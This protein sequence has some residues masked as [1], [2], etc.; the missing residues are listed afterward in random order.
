MKKKQSKPSRKNPFSQD[1]NEYPDKDKVRQA[2]TDLSNALLEKADGDPDLAIKLL[3]NSIS[4]NAP[5][6]TAG[7]WQ[8]THPNSIKCGSDSFYAKIASE[9][10]ADFNMIQT[11]GNIPDGTYFAAAQSIAAYLEDIVSGTQVWQAVR[12]IY[13]RTYGAQ[14]PFYEVDPEDYFDDDINIQDLKLL[15]WQALSRCGNEEERA[16]SPISQ[17]VSKMSEIAFDILVEN[18]DSAPSA[19]RV[20]DLI[21]KSL[22]SDEYYQIR[23]L[24][25]W[26]NTQNPL[27][28][29]PFSHEDILDSADDTFDTLN[30]KFEDGSFDYEAA[31]YFEECNRAWLKYMSLLGCHT[32]T[33]LSELASIHKMPAAAE[34]IST[35]KK[36]PSD[37]YIIEDTKGSHIIVRNMAGEIMNVVRNSFGKGVDWDTSKSAVMSLVKFGDEYYQNGL[38]TFYSSAP[39]SKG[40]VT[41]SKFPDNLF[42]TIES[43]VRKMHGHRIFYCKTLE[44]VYDILNQFTSAIPKE[45]FDKIPFHHNFLLMLSSTDGPMIMTDWCPVFE[46]KKNPFFGAIP[47]NILGD[48]QF[49][50]LGEA[51]LPDDIIEYIVSHKLL[52]KAYMNAYQGKRV[53]KAIVQ[54]YLAFWL[55]FNRVSTNPIPDFLSTDPNLD[56]GEDYNDD[57]FDD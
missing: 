32:R 7:D 57:D 45:E 52:S 36:Y 35:V 15:C 37:N 55:R 28:A 8:S 42:E 27:T 48:E 24:A 40:E 2:L 18:F 22:R 30:E 46:D 3:M 12:N 54:D 56:L 39:K 17:L 16:F 50:F 26:L 6:F 38:C 5:M 31:V 43:F 47:K 1:T 9:L 53:G 49:A 51:R 44:D 41:L 23:A 13:K 25:L 19:T 34:K 33:I 10:F 4:K 20:A 29:T 14:L 21:R 11:D